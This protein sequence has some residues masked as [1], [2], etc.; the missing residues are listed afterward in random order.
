MGDYRW[1][2]GSSSN[3]GLFTGVCQEIKEAIRNLDFLPPFLRMPLYHIIGDGGNGRQRE[4]IISEGEKTYYVHNQKGIIVIILWN[5]IS[6][7]ISA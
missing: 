1:S 5:P 2:R 4:I 3:S 6:L 7:I